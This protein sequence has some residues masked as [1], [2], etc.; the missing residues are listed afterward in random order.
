MKSAVKL[1][2]RRGYRRVRL[3]DIAA[4]AGVSKATVYH[5]FRN[6]DT[7]LARAIEAR[8]AEKEAALEPGAASA[9]GSAAARLRAFLRQ[10]WAMALTPQAGIWQQL[11]VSEIATDAP[12]VFDAWIRGIVRRWR[13][14]AA[15]I[16]EGQ[17]RGE[18]RRDVDAEV[19][20]R[21]IVSGLIHQALFHVHFG[22]RRFAPCRV[23]RIRDAAIGHLFL[24]LRRPA[25]PA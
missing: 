15:L 22:A 1:L 19:A 6:K 16:R 5:Y 7:L 18:F 11:L 4:D 3:E 8:M 14:V 12:D 10:F 24:G 2:L 9:H 21:M 13:R 25:R 23:D 20:A 17:Q